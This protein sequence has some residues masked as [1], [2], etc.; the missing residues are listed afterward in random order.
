VLLQKSSCFQLFLLLRRCVVGSLVTV[1]LQMFLWFWQWNKFENRSIF[2]EVKAYETK[3]GAILYRA[4]SWNTARPLNNLR[5][6]S[7]TCN[8]LPVRN[9]LK[10]RPW[11]RLMPL[12]KC[13]DTDDWTYS[14]FTF[15]VAW[16]AVSCAV[17]GTDYHPL[18]FRSI[19]MSALRVDTMATL[20]LSQKKTVPTYLLLHVCQI[21]SG[22]NKNRKDCPGFPWQN[23]T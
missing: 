2:D 19:Q 14:Y 23:C 15:L 3:C 9:H 7:R 1:L 4:I 13:R 22:F 10:Y 17:P 16:S 21:W 6:H 12:N 18:C 20:A 11:S 8:Q 5:R